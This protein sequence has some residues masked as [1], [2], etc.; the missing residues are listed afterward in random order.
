[1]K[2]KTMWEIA[3][4][5]DRDLAVVSECP[6]NCTAPPVGYDPE[7]PEDELKGVEQQEHLFHAEIRG[8][9]DNGETAEEIIASFGGWYARDVYEVEAEVRWAQVSGR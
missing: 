2:T 6:N 5:M 9:L 3:E 4:Q 8:R 1:M 7:P